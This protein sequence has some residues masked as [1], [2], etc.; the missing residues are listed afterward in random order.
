M[1]SS[2]ISPS[3]CSATL[4]RSSTA[5]TSR[6][7]SLRVRFF[8]IHS[9]GIPNPGEV[10]SLGI[11]IPL[12][13]RRPLG[14]FHRGCEVEP[15]PPDIR[16]QAAEAAR[17]A[18]SHILALEEEELVPRGRDE[19]EIGFFC[20]CGCLEVVTMT[21]AQ[22]RGRLRRLALRPQTRLGSRYGQARGARRD[23]RIPR[24]RRSRPFRR[25]AGGRCKPE[26]TGSIPVRSTSAAMVR[27]RTV[28][29]FAERPVH[30]AAPRAAGRV[31]RRNA[32]WLPP[33][34]MEDTLPL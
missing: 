20:E 1:A 26:V 13:E 11:R 15:E 3:I 16:P 6:A 32:S 33:A 12:G 24:R 22:V 30:P 5:P 10:Q 2:A 25:R 21:R 28:D 27:L 17:A 19:R 31:P 14:S 7:R 18:N 9:P 8:A 34:G 23:R 4:R 29:A